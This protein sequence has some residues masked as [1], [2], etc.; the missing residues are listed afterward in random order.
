M[1]VYIVD[2]LQLDLR[3]Q[4]NKAG[5]MWACQKADCSRLYTTEAVRDHLVLKQIPLSAH[6]LELACTVDKLQQ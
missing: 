5:Y 3:Y 1:H 6:G 4:Q 2:H